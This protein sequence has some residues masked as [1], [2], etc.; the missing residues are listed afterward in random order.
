MAGAVADGG[1]PIATEL[2]PG[3][4]LMTRADRRPPHRRTGAKQ[5]SHRYANAD[6]GEKVNDGLFLVLPS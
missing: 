2:A 3:Q 4:V 6:R 1:I 5:R